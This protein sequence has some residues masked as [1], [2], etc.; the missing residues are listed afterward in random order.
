MTPAERLLA[1]LPAVFQ[2]RDEQGDLARLLGAFGAMFF[3]GDDGAGDRRAALPGIERS[4]QAIPALFAPGPDSG[5]GTPRTPDAFVPWLAAW[6]G[7]TPHALFSTDE[8]RRIV[9][10]IVP[11][12]GLR[13]SRD[14]LQRLLLLCFG[15]PERGVVVEDRP[16]VGLVV[17]DA[18]I[19]SSSRL[20]ADRPFWFRVV[21]VL[22]DDDA[23]RLTQDGLG[24]LERRLRAIIDFA[25]P[26]HTAYEL[27][28]Q[29]PAPA[30]AASPGAPPANGGR[31]T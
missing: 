23:A 25:K 13:G 18:R 4:L 31:P 11:L 12:Y 28:L 9:A 21:I 20:I 26:A 10:A 2:Q 1:S 6:L 16:R 3:D 14:Y 15:L 27:L 29:A 17:G 19:G 5:P 24:P 22:G 30:A 8:L 7:F